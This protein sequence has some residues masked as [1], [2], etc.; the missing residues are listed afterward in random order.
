MGDRVIFNRGGVSPAHRNF[1][2]D[3][4]RTLAIL[5]M[6]SSHTS[7]LIVWES[8]REWSRFVLLIEPL[9]ASL[10]LMLVGASL[11]YSWHAAGI[12]ARWSWYRKQLV[13]AGCLWIISCLFYLA[14]D[15]L[16]WP[17]AIFLSG[18]LATI[19]YT[20]VLGMFVISSPYSIALLVFISTAL[21]SLNLFLDIH[22]LKWFMVNAGNSPFLPL[23]I[24]ACLGALGVLA[25]ESRKRWVQPLVLIVAL[26]LLGAI[27]YR[28]SFTEIFS[29]P[30]G[31]F[32]TARTFVTGPNEART[33]KS[34]PYYN[35]RPILIPV[36]ASII[37]VIYG[38]LANLNSAGERFSKYFFPMGRFSLDIYIL[39]LSLLASLV[40]VSGGLR[41]L[42]KTWQGDAVILGLFLICQG[43]AMGRDY[44]KRRKKVGRI[45]NSFH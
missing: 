37:V 42:Q 27:R 38:G 35:L 5:L 1:A 9:T 3:G 25:L 36:I 43:W 31:R 41:P 40:V 10:F 23:L 4:L 12:H 24:F 11:V 2:L 30:L 22:H 15:G 16:R 26:A 34:I 44:F 7:R 29:N 28:Y 21:I 8:R 33:V 17:D 20:S 14:E 19:A 32:E 6:I 45:A 18:I 39:H 13:R